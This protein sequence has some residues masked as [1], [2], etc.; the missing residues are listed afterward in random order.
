[1]KLNHVQLDSVFVESAVGN[2]FSKKRL[3]F[4]HC[5]NDWAHTACGDDLKAD[6]ARVC[7]MNAACNT[8]GNTV[9]K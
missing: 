5:G 4:L 7:A 1:M 8:D 6:A 9:R 3:I 2:K